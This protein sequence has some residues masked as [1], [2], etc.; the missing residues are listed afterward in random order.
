M[1][2][3]NKRTKPLLS[4]CIPTYNRADVLF[5]C[6]NSIVQNKSFNDDIEIF[7]SDNASSDNTKDIVQSF[8]KKYNNIIYIRQNKNIG[9][10]LNFIY[11]LEN[12]NGHFRKLHNDYNIFTEN[13][14]QILL[15]HIKRERDSKDLLY[16]IHSQKK[17]FQIIQN[18]NEFINVV[19]LSATWISSYGFWAEDFIN[20]ENKKEKIATQ[21]MQVDWFLRIFE[22]KNRCKICYGDYTTR[23]KFKSS[24]GGYNFIKVQHLNY[25]NMFIPYYQ[26]GVINI[27]TI[28][29][30]KRDSYSFLLNWLWKLRVKKDKEYSYSTNNGIEVLFKS[31]GHY[32][33]FY[34]D[35]IKKIIKY[36]LKEI[37]NLFNYKTKL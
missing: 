14:L 24:Q 21:F 11:V 2:N 19:K 30:L 16:F 6:I 22:K 12:A 20:L 36:S 17:D 35:P 10:E 28:K 31:C 33:W 13:G 32:Y 37:F 26:K 1:E 25:I 27:D 7:I 18:L 3:I 9:G 8:V 4:I 29:R 15:N 23:Y 5:H 34:T